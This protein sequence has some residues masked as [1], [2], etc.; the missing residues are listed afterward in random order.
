MADVLNLKSH[1]P[2]CQSHWNTCKLP[3]FRR[4]IS[5]FLLYETYSVAYQN[6]ALN[7]LVQKQDSYGYDDQKD[8][9]LRPL[10]WKNI[11]TDQTGL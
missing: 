8:F 3:Q 5:V 11:N 4:P 7:V 1:H 9:E 2:K 6:K 10:A